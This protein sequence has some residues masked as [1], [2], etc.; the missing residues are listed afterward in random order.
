MS[1]LYYSGIIPVW[2]SLIR[3]VGHWARRTN[4]QR[5]DSGF[6]AVESYLEPFRNIEL[7]YDNGYIA[8]LPGNYELPSIDEP[9]YISPHFGAPSWI[10]RTYFTKL[11]IMAEHG[12]LTHLGVYRDHWCFDLLNVEDESS[13]LIIL[14]HVDRRTMVRQR[15]SL[16]IWIGVFKR[17]DI[18]S[19][20]PLNLVFQTVTKLGIMP[21]GS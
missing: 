16:H 10:N 4:H 9:L 2:Y 8:F 19:Y 15:I 7:W 3:C 12:C 18:G 17:Q 6:L 11:V 14:N 21:W 13:F 5:S 20:Q 1:I